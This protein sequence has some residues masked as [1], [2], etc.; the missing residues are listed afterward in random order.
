MNGPQKIMIV[1]HAEKPVEPPPYGVTEDGEEDKY[2]L[3]VR[4]W[5]RAGALIHFFEQ[6]YRDGIETPQRIFA[7][8]TTQDDPSVEEKDAKSHRPHETLKPLA[9]KL[10]IDIDASVPVGREDA[11]VQA[12]KATSGIVLVAWEHKRIPKIARG[13][14]SDAPDW[15][16]DRFDVV[17][18][19]D[20]T[21]AGDYNFK[22]VNQDLL[23]GD[24]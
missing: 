23:D 11:M 8:G 3:C 19:L 12:L 10:G 6:P 9:R 16:G 20:R 14:F 5:Q 1:R 22:I 24:A 21:A 18:I 2:S 4:G 7:A 15:D 17:W 13:F